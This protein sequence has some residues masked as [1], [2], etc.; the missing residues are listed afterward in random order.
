[1]L[2]HLINDILFPPKCVLCRKVL[3][4]NETDYC[5]DCRIYAPEYTKAKSNI[6][7]L[8]GWTTVWYYSDDVRK[9]I[10]RYKFGNKRNYANAYGR[11]L[12][13]K[14]HEDLPKDIDYITWAPVSKLRKLKRGYDQVELFAKVIAKEL[15][16]PLKPLL[17]KVR[18]TPAQSSLPNE[19]QRKANVMGAYKATDKSLIEDKRILL[20]DDVFTTGATA[21]ECA[22]TLLFAGAKDVYFASLAVTPHNKK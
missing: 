4:K 9:S 7:F 2:I 8:A 5:N 1:M 13:M 11:S 21:S 6:S 20:L 12:A 3:K 22:K 18:H 15:S 14:I 16:I 19:A 10:L 17:K